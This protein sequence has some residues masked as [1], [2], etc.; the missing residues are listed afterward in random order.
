LISL[1]LV[2]KLNILDQLFERY[3][4]PQAVWDEL[5]LY[6]HPDLNQSSFAPLKT[7]IQQITSVNYLINQMDVGEAEAMI[8]YH[9]M[10]TDFLLIDDQK[11]RQIAE[12]LGVRCVGSIGLMIKAKE[13]GL[14]QELRPGFQIW[15]KEGRYFGVILLNS[16]LTSQNE[17]SL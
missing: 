11:A 15:L 16:I 3:Y 9:E 10:R 17:A 12:S 14:V 2:G 8:L 5:Q 1:A 13:K 7:H 4:I 6:D